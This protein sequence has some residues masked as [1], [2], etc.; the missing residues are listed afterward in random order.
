MDQTSSKELLCCEGISCLAWNKDH[1]SY[2]IL[3][4]SVC[5]I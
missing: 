5:S 4:L 2:F 1:T 3:Y